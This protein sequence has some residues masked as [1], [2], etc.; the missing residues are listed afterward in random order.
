[1][2]CFSGRM[3]TLTSGLP[4]IIQD[5]NDEKRAGYT[6]WQTHIAQVLKDYVAKG[7]L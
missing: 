2:V 7:R 6:N 5:S 3:I 1:M 4:Q